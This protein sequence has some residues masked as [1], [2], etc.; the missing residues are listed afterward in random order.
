MLV[1]V[2]DTFR[3]LFQRST[4]T[5]TISR[6]HTVYLRQHTPTQTPKKTHTQK[7]TLAHTQRH[8]RKTAPLTATIGSALT[9]V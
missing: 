1:L 7:H 4:R 3:V 5:L 2:P 6:T 9:K 8:V